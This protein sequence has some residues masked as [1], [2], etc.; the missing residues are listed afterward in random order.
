M[1][2]P[3]HL[4]A[5]MVDR[6]RAAG[7][8]RSDRVAQAMRRV[9]RHAFLPTTPLDEAYA[10]RGTPTTC[11]SMLDQLDVH[12]GH[13]VLEIGTGTGYTAALLDELAGN[14]TTLDIDPD[15]TARA[16]LA[17]DT[18]DHH[19]VRVRTRNGTLGE[20][21]HAPY[22]RI[23]ITATAHDIPPMI[24]T[25]LAPHGRL[26]IPLR[27]R[28][29]TRSIAFD[30]D[31]DQLRSDSIEPSTLA[32]LT[33]QDGEHHGILD[34]AGHVTLHWDPDQPL[35]TNPYTGL[36]GILDE[37]RVEAWSGITAPF[38]GVWLRLSHTEPGTCTIT[39]SRRSPAL[40][41]RPRR[42][43]AYLTTHHGELGAIGHGTIGPQLAHRLCDH[44][45]AWHRDPDA[46]PTITA[47]PAG[48]DAA[49][50]VIRKRHCLLVVG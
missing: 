21:R 37:P 7:H 2:S 42:S 32:P 4:R 36:Y 17:L 14:V 26:V 43:L 46:R 48:G 40:A 23:L 12:P 45:H 34:P 6:L 15:T 8:A 39:G 13:H 38:D 16:R 29:Q 31:G 33:G 41:D 24:W 50:T 27:W 49:G 19:H 20:P 44:V 47:H 9:P 3:A 22:D 11:A 25:Q 28:G 35:A 18:T 1:S 5:R 10:E 30:R